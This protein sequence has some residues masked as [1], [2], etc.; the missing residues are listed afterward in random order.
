[1]SDLQ[2][3]KALIE[4]VLVFG[5]LVAG[6]WAATPKGLRA[7]KRVLRWLFWWAMRP[8]LN[9]LETHVADAEIHNP[10]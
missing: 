8:E 1:M 4:F 9:K 6:L 7:V 10:D 5:G 2:E 3:A